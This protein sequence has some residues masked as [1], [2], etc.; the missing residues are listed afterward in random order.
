MKWY[1]QI[2]PASGGTFHVGGFDTEDLADKSRAAYDAK[3]PGDT[4][5]DP[6]E[7]VDTYLE[8]KYPVPVMNKSTGLGNVIIHSDGTETSE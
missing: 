8:D 2:N 7:D 6:F 5:G 1:Y 3:Y 4:T